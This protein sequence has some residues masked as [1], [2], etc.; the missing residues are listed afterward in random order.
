MA[1]LAAGGL[2][3]GTAAEYLPLLGIGSLAFYLAQ[4]GSGAPP[5]RRDPTEEERSRHQHMT[6]MEVGGA[7][8]SHWQTMTQKVHLFGVSGKAET[9]LDLTNAGYIENPNISPLAEMFNDHANLAAYDRDDT[10]LSMN[11]GTGEVRPKRRMPIVST[12]SEEISHPKNPNMTTN[13]GVFK[14]FPNEPNRTQ[15]R[16]AMENIDEK[17]RADT[18]LQPH[19]EVAYYN[20]APG[21]SF[22]YDDQ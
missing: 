21:Q 16:K 12:L 11:V 3:L 20:R 7:S 15:V 8:A 9:S 13:L 4:Y 18:Q 17:Q 10:F 1:A 6:E 5:P 14:H 19:F 2:F 22:R